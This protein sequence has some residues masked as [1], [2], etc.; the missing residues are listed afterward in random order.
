MEFGFG[1]NQDGSGGL[2]RYYALIHSVCDIQGAFQVGENQVW[3][4]YDDDGLPRYHALISKRPFKLAFQVGEN[5][6]WAAYDDDDG[7]PLYSA[8]IH[9]AIS[10]RPFK[11]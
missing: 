4:A 9:S 8:L 1:K 5:R 2:A 3:A 11:L 6:V 10:K 7:K